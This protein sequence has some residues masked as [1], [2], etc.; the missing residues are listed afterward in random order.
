[1]FVHVRTAL[2]GMASVTISIA[3]VS[4]VWIAPTSEIMTTQAGEIAIGKGMIRP[5]LKG[6]DSAHVTFAAELCLF[7]HQKGRD[8]VVNT[9]AGGTGQVFT[10]MWIETN[11]VHLCMRLVAPGTSRVDGSTRRFGRVSD[12]LDRG[13]ISVRFPTFVATDAAYLSS[14][15]FGIGA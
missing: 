14:S 8:A 3:S 2:F 15:V 12:V 4:I 11:I 13:I 10:D 1:M 5:L 9:V 6:I 7:V